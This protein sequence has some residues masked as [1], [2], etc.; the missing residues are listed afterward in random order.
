MKNSKVQ[1]IATGF[2]T[3]LAITAALVAGF[4][5]HS[6]TSQ[7]AAAVGTLAA[8]SPTV[9]IAA[10]PAA[11]VARTAVR[12]RT[13][14]VTPTSAGSSTKSARTAAY[15]AS[16]GELAEAKSILAGLIAKYPILKGTTVSIG[17]TPGGYQAVAYY[18]SG[19]IIVSSSHTA[20]L[21]R[22]LTHEVWHII[23]WRD[24]GRI[25]WGENVPR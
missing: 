14:Q 21:S 23:D 2:I 12:Q 11:T 16:T 5:P 8:A 20:S 24:N 10:E 4:A 22:I 6:A 15:K 17:T 18:Q 7:A 9:R 3:T 1:I 25:D 13:P 19:R